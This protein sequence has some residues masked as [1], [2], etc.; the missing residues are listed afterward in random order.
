MQSLKLK[1]QILFKADELNFMFN[2]LKLALENYTTKVL[3]QK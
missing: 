3:P 2:K 1:Q